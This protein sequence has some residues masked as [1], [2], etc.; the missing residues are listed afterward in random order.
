MKLWNGPYISNSSHLFLVLL[1]ADVWG[2]LHA[3]G[4]LGAAR[5][6]RDEDQGPG[7]EGETGEQDEWQLCPYCCA[8]ETENSKDIFCFTCD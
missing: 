6:R 1:P 7:Q 2:F 8:L 5:L 3:V 4:E